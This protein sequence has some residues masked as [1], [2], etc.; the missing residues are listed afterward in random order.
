MKLSLPHRFVIPGDPFLAVDAGMGAR[1][2][3]PQIFLR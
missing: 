2:G 1:E 3:D